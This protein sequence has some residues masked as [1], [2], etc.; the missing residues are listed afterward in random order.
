MLI[1]HN[2]LV[3]SC[4]VLSL[5]SSGNWHQLVGTLGMDLELFSQVQTNL[6]MRRMSQ[7]LPRLVGEQEVEEEVESVCIR[8]SLENTSHQALQVTIS[9]IPIVFFSYLYP[10][11]HCIG[12]F[13]SY[14]TV[15]GASI[16]LD[17]E[18]YAVHLILSF[19]ILSYFIGSFPIKS[20]ILY[21]VLSCSIPS[22]FY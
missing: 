8:V 20:N 14:Q 13:F 16:A 7:Q 21:P 3:L 6:I 11:I 22:F 18:L 1:S 10:A 5:L 19:R 15:S 12:L 9:H 2:R 4:L 17:G